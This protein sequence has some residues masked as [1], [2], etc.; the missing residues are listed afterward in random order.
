MRYNENAEFTQLW[1]QDLV[2]IGFSNAGADIAF[3]TRMATVH[4]VLVMES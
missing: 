3:I 2:L 4:T 1:S